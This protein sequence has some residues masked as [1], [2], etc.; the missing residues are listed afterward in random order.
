MSKLGI[1]VVEGFFGPQWELNKRLSYAGFLSLVGGA[2]YIYAPK[3]DSHLRKA[4]RE[5]WSDEYIALL[6]QM[7]ESFRKENITFGV[8]LSPFELGLAISAADEALLKEKFALLNSLGVKLLGLFFDDMPV[9]EGLAEAQIKTMSIATE[10]F[11]GQVIFCPSFYSYDPILEKVFG[12][13]PEGYLSDIADGIPLSAE[14]AWTG[15]KVISPVIDT[16]HIKEVTTLL[17]R[18]PFLWE[19]VFAN[20]GPK[21][22]KFLK[23]RPFTGRDGNLN[24]LI[25]GMGLNMMNQAELSKITFLATLNYFKLADADLA[26]EQ[27]LTELCSVPFRDFIQSHWKSF[28]ED[29]LDK[30]SDEKKQALIEELRTFSDAGALE[31]REWL[32]GKFIVGSECLTD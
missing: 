18:P 26:F 10:S 31:I 2:F 15:P 28:N 14:V 30:I 9:K 11:K 12:K 3:Q 5:P 29:G 19:N 32:E 20:D 8:G 24:D 22:C 1:G 6:K 13:M 16:A 27:A 25:S 17:K 23:L 21:N 4:W 7:I